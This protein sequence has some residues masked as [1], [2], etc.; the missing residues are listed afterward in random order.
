MGRE[1]GLA[2]SGMADA[3]R[4]TRAQVGG[5]RPRVSL[6]VVDLAE[7]ASTSHSGETISERTHPAKAGRALR[8]PPHIACDI[9]GQ[10]PQLARG[11][12]GVDFVE[13]IY[14]RGDA[15]AARPWGAAVG[16]RTF[17]TSSGQLVPAGQLAENQLTIAS[18]LRAVKDAPESR[19]SKKRQSPVASRATV[20]ISSLRACAKVLARTIR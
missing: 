15:H 6:K 17:G 19:R 8:P 11:D 5:E 3:P 14:V 20:T 12:L 9:A 7:H 18:Y 13:A 4:R 16:L 2:G 10:L 1:D